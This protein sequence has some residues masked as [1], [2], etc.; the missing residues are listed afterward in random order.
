VGLLDVLGY[1]VVDGAHSHPDRTA[2]FVGD[3]MDRGPRQVEV[4]RIVRAMH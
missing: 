1:R 2:V 3:L 4:V